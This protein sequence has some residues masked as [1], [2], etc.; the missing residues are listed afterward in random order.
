[1]SKYNINLDSYLVALEFGSV[2]KQAEEKNESKTKL[3]DQ[4]AEG[5]FFIS[6]YFTKS[7][8]KTTIGF[9]V[10]FA[11]RDTSLDPKTKTK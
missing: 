10:T 2:V 7:K 3:I 11:D 1:L 6:H 9:N 5:W 8:N 4:P